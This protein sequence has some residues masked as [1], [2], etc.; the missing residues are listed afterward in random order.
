MIILRVAMGRGWSKETVNEISTAIVFAK[1]PTVHEQ[2]QD[3]R[4]TIHN[5]KDH[6]SGPGMPET[7]SDM[8]IEKRTSKNGIASLA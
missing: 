7:R 8:S 6:I 3:A 5:T 2:S 4:M 1:P